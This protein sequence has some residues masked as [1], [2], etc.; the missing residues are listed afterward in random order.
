M[1]SGGQTLG[2]VEAAKEE[3]QKEKAA[4][5]KK[6][7]E[8]EKLAKAYEQQHRLQEQQMAGTMAVILTFPCN[9]LTSKGVNGLNSSFDNPLSFNMCLAKA[10]TLSPCQDA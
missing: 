6:L 7:H 1:I 5:Q 9:I 4:H 2:Q 3:A 10:N 8:Q